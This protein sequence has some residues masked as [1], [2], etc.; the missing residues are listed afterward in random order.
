MLRRDV[1]IAKNLSIKSE[2][3]PPV[4]TI[5][6]GEVQCTTLEEQVDRIFEELEKQQL[7]QFEIL[8]LE[9][10]MLL[11]PGTQML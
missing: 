11:S 2:S 7:E 3:E 6:P 5:Y 4:D 9:I 10:R 8:D 1:S